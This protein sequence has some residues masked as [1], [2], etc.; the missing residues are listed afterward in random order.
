MVMFIFAAT[1]RGQEQT[2]IKSDVEHSGFG[3][4]VVKATRIHD[5]GALMVGGRGGWIINHT[6]AIGGGGYG[7]VNDVD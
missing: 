1:A 4:P 3:G 5:Q 6:L 7:V 2:L